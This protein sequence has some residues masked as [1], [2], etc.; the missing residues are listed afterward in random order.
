LV[1]PKVEANPILTRPVLLG[2]KSYCTLALIPDPT[3]DVQL[4]HNVHQLDQG[5]A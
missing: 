5:S 1:N 2:T 3:G 4:L